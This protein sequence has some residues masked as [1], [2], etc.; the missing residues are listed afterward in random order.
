VVVAPGGGDCLVCSTGLA[1]GPFGFVALAKKVK[2]FKPGS[3]G[4]ARAID[5]ILP[6][7]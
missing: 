5:L 3:E 7:I 6:R 2:F 4:T 1:V